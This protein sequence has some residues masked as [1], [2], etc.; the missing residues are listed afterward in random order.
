MPCRLT[1]S[2]TD[3]LDKDCMTNEGIAAVCKHGCPYVAEQTLAC[4]FWR[5]YL[6]SVA[7]G[8][9]GLA[10]SR[11]QAVKTVTGT[12]DLHATVYPIQPGLQTCMLHLLSC[13]IACCN[14]SPANLHAA[15]PYHKSL[16]SWLH[17]SCAQMHTSA[18]CTEHNC[19]FNDFLCH[20][21]GMGTVDHE[22]VL[23]GNLPSKSLYEYCFHPD[24]QC[25]KVSICLLLKLADA[26]P[27]AVASSACN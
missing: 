15:S 2:D 27:P 21:S 11:G 18:P 24:Q 9:W 8:V 6:C 13:K 22:K 1:M 3:V 17:V 5:Q 20:T 4:R 25:W 10:L 14:F 12:L 19:R 23:V 7:C 16:N 26:G